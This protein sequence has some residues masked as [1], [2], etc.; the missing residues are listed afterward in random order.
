MFKTRLGAPLRVMFSNCLKSLI[1]SKKLYLRVTYLNE[2]GHS[3]YKMKTFL[4]IWRLVLKIE[5]KKYPM[6]TSQQNTVLG[7]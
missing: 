5:K 6:A 2:Y 3:K 4:E 1:F 7:P